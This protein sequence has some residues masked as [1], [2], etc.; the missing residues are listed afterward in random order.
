[1]D[2]F[3]RAKRVAVRAMRTRMW[4]KAIGEEDP[5]MVA[6]IPQLVR[7]NKLG[8]ITTQK[9]KRGREALQVRANGRADD[10]G[11]ARVLLRVRA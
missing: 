9:P 1:M 6:H 2:A 3:E 5:L 8:M 11:R 10:H 4:Q 7:I